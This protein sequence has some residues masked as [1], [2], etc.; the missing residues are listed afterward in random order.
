MGS[1][2]PQN[3][4]TDRRKNESTI[5]GNR[6]IS[7]S[8]VEIY[9]IKLIDA[10]P[11]TTQQKKTNASRHQKT[12]KQKQQHHIATMAAQVLHHLKK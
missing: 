9:V 8:V 11:M 2:H 4:Q 3:R 10:M 6:T 5:S 12:T 1:A 7:T